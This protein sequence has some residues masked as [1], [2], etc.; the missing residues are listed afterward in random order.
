VHGQV[1]G[2]DQHHLVRKCRCPVPADWLSKV[3]QS[4]S[5]CSRFFCQGADYFLGRAG[6]LGCGPEECAPACSVRTPVELVEGVKDRQQFTPRGFLPVYGPIPHLQPCVLPPLQRG[7]NQRFL[8]GVAAVE[9]C[10]ADAGAGEHSVNR[11]RRV[12]MGGE[13][14]SAAFSSFVSVD[15]RMPITTLQT[16]QCETIVF[17]GRHARDGSCCSRHG[18]DC[19]DLRAV[20]AW[21]RRGW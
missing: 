9:R 13:Q 21:R 16:H 5:K 7:S 10:G 15:S 3:K 6:V 4:R 17:G 2:D 1:A 12:A 11:C 20:L 8:A 14:L 19:C 18:P